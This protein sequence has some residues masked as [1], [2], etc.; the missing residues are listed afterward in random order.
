[1]WGGVR[2]EWEGEGGG[3][4]FVAGRRG[5]TSLISDWSSDVCSSDLRPWPAEHFPPHAGHGLGLTHPEAPFLVREANETLLAGDVVTLEI[6]RAS[7][8]ERGWVSGEGGADA[9]TQSAELGEGGKEARRTRS[10]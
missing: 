6:G 10:G 4:N 7:C 9:K 1:G 5:H 3:W 8:R 2:G